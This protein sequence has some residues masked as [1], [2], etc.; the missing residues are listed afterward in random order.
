[1]NMKIQTACNLLQ[2]TYKDI[3]RR[4]WYLIKHVVVSVSTLVFLLY[5]ASGIHTMNANIAKNN[6]TIQEIA[7][8]SNA[9]IISDESEIIPLQAALISDEASIE[10]KHGITYLSVWAGTLVL[11]QIE[12][13]LSIKIR[14]NWEKICR[15]R[16]N[17]EW[18]FGC[19]FSDS[20]L[21]QWD[22]SIHL[23]GE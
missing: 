5:A 8:R 17:A 19:M 20:R 1:M 21:I 6:E 23:S 12:P 18:K 4:M 9:K 13:N 15:T 22:I 3:T 10:A 16:A 11:G 7:D 2:K 14:G